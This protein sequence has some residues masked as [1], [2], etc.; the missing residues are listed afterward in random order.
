MRYVSAIFVFL[1]MSSVSCKK[2]YT[3]ECVNSNGTYIAGEVEGTKSKAKKHCEGLSSS[4]TDCVA[5]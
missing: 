5:K 2:N 4:S 1:I 3:C